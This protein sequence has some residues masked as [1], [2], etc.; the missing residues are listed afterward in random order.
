MSYEDRVRARAEAQE[1]AKANLIPWKPGESG[2]PSG[3]PLGARNRFGELFLEDVYEDWKLWGKKVLTEVRE[4][5]PQDYLKVVS[6]LLPKI[7]HIKEDMIEDMSDNE[8]AD[9]LASVH[10]IAIG[11]RRAKARKRIRETQSPQEAEPE[12]RPN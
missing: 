12:G 2:N 3:R 4:T 10:T 5:K 9:I 8:L 11:N 1:K 7:L 6:T